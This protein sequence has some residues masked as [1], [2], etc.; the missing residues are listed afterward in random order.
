MYLKYAFLWE[1]YVHFWTQESLSCTSNCAVLSQGFECP[2]Q[3]VLFQLKITQGLVDPAIQFH[4][5]LYT[6]LVCEWIC[7]KTLLQFGI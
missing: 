1:L 4:R 2:L 6:H 7:F 3:L 5:I